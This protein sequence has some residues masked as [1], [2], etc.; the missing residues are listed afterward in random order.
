[1]TRFAII[2]EPSATYEEI[3]MFLWDNPKKLWHVDGLEADKR[4]F[5]VDMISEDWTVDDAINM[6]NDLLKSSC[7]KGRAEKIDVT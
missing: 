7:I 3:D 5:T 4:K 6:A 1:M 2:F